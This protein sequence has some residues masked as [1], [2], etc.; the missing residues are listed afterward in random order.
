MYKQVAIGSLL[1]L[2]MLPVA[3][4]KSAIYK[5]DAGITIKYTDCLIVDDNGAEA[6]DVTFT[7]NEPCSK[8]YSV[9]SGL[10]VVV[11]PNSGYKNL[12]H[13]EA[14]L[15]GRSE[16]LTSKKQQFGRI[17]GIVLS[18]IHKEDRPLIDDVS[19]YNYL[20]TA[21]L[22]CK[23]KLVTVDWTDHLTKRERESLRKNPKMP[24]SFKEVIDGLKCS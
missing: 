16:V 19:Q 6:N 14:S 1:F 2:L 4:A 22:F 13:Y 23:T 18:A 11:H 3:R 17:R 20:W 21:A 9:G 7:V 8:K 12:E 10:Q 5:T 24:I 15:S